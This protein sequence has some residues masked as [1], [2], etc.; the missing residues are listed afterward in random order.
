VIRS[1]GHQ[2][3]PRANHH[4]IPDV[5]AAIS[6][7]LARP[8]EEHLA[9]P[10]L[11]AVV[12]EVPD[13]RP[14]EAVAPSLECR[15]ARVLFRIE[16]LPDVVEPAL[17]R[18]A[19]MNAVVAEIPQAERVQRREKRQRAEATIEAAVRRQGLVTRIVSEHEE[20][21]D[22]DHG[23]QGKQGLSEPR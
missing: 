12:R 8:R 6:A 4:M 9:P 13:R 14:E 1:A 3:G 17:V 22:E 18:V 21:A 20:T 5:L 10:N 11:R 16:R 23:A 7:D 2:H 15:Q 19:M